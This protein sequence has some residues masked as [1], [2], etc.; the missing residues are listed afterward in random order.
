MKSGGGAH[1]ADI[2]FNYL[3]SIDKTYIISVCIIAY[4][5]HEKL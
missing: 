2:N 4:I 1:I 3:L 5:N